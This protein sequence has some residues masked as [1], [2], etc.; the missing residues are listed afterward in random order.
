MMPSRLACLSLAA[1]AL[2]L[3][4]GRAEPGPGAA[5]FAPASLAPVTSPIDPQPPPIDPLPPEGPREAPILSD[6]PI[7][8][9][10]ATLQ[11]LRQVEAP[12][13]PPPSPVAWLPVKGA[14][15]EGPFLRPGDVFRGTTLD[16]KVVFVRPEGDVTLEAGYWLTYVGSDGESPSTLRHGPCVG[17][18]FLFP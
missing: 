7:L 8:R 1:L 11:L 18:S 16:R 15:E 13:E 9:E 10:R 4:S 14:L 5:S 6:V 3:S 17:L 12:L 2:A